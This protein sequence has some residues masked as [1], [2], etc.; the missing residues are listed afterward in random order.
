MENRFGL[1]DLVVIV[2]LIGVIVSIWIAMVQ[3]D[4]QWEEMK[5]V[6]VNLEQLTK[7]QSGLRR[8][9]NAMKSTL[10]EGVRYVG[11]ANVNTDSPTVE[12]SVQL[13]DPFER[14][15]LAQASEGYAEGDWLIDAFG[16]NVS[17]ITP[18]ITTDYYGAR[19][20]GFVMETLIT[21][22]PETLQNIPLLAK[23]WDISDDGLT[24][25]YQLREDVIFSDGEPMTSED[26][27]F[28]FDLMNNPEINAPDS[29]EFY[30]P[31]KSC[32]ANGPY[33]VVFEMREP[34]FLALGLTGRRLVLPKHFYEKFTPDQINK[35]P[36]LLLGSGPY[37]L[38]DPT[39]WAPGK[40]VELVRN[41]RYWGEPSAF[42]KLIW[43]E[44]DQDVVR[45]TKFRNGEI[46]VLVPTP[47]QFDELKKDSSLMAHT[48]ALAYNKI[49]ANYSYIAWNQE[50][51]GKPTKFADKR[52]RQ[53]M[54]YLTP[55]E[56]M[57][58]DIF[59]GYSTP[60]MGPFAKGSPQADPSIVPRPFDVAKGKALLEEA[61]WFDRGGILT[62]AKGEQFRFKLT[63]P[64]GSNTYEKI[65]LA[66]KDAYA[67]VGIIMDPNP[68]EFS[69]MLQRVDEQDFE[70]ITLAWSVNAVESDIRDTF[71]SSQIGG[72]KRNYMSYRNAELD[73][74]IEL[75]RRTVNEEERLPIWRKCHQI[76]YE[77]QP[78]T[79]M[80]NSQSLRL[81][82]K[83]VHNV[84]R[85]TA[86]INDYTEW[87][88]PKP[89]QKY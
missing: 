1:K 84:E 89:L 45:L 6:N 60:A 35:T 13:T 38:K 76:L 71:H 29:R 55:R 82:D 40:L 63:Y 44:I 78:Y 22:D 23:S 34:H 46:D 64:A 39:N 67:R 33:E 32:K 11:P 59:L 26:V 24:I 3:F 73:K 62:N 18:L 7:E 66:L 70:A 17:R 74:L 12:K 8:Q 87:F 75:A 36:G 83:R 27:V 50:R 30:Y 86:G 77:D 19:I 58:K 43:H 14:M 53:A 56:R 42:D 80:F 25:T 81:I 41:E 15:K 61:G 47:E 65:V 69:V 28:S 37:R 72:G 2:L 48:N 79:F 21:L 88:V 85:V 68:L 49:P 10:D 31:I 57:A 52:V 5:S 54:T 51:D 20:Q 9:L 16:T 4:R